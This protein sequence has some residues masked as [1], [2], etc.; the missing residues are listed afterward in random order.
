MSD[1][2]VLDLAFKSVM[3]ILLISA[4]AMITI[5]VV[6]IVISVI[7][8]A[9]QINEQTLSF[10]PKILCLTVVLAVTGPWILQTIL[11]FT[12]NIFSMI[13]TLNH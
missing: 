3:T 7:Q 1:Q 9:T 8:A 12:R 10:V 4:P 5:L 6:G 13:P 11:E 2:A